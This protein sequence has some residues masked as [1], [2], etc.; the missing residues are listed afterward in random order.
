MQYDIIMSKQSEK[1][2][3]TTATNTETVLIVNPS[4][5]SGTTGKNWNDFYLKV[6]EFFGQ[7]PEV[8]FTTKAGDGTSLT[9][10]Y[11]QKGFKNI[12]AIGGDGT[13]NE[14][15][16]GFFIFNGVEENNYNKRK[17]VKAVVAGGVHSKG[18]SSHNDR[19]IDTT[20]SI[21]RRPPVKQINP[22]A[23]FGI[24][25]SGTRNVLVKSLGLPAG[26]E[27]C[28]KY[29][30]ASKMQKK[31]DVISVTV[32][33]FPD[34]DD[35]DSKN[36]HSKLA[37]TR[38]FLNAAEIGVAA[39]IIDRSK[40]IRDK[41]KSRMVSTVS[42][43]VATLPT[44]QS[45]LCEISVDDG[46]ENILTKMTMV[47]IANGR[48][49]GGGF[50][51][52]PKASMSDGL[53]DIVILKNSG[54]FKM[55]E[56][57]ISMKNGNYT[58]DDQDIIYIQAKKVSIKPKQEEEHKGKKRGDITVTIDGEPIGILPATFQ[59]HQDALTIKM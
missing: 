10:E 39:E 11:L 27:E 36:T 24:I 4:S 14:V 51:A 59:V 8:A 1:S 26:S 56:E 25:S 55:L 30:A 7:N 34:N 58:S 48:Y 46:R 19:G 18:D 47:V 32:T 54:S 13:I 15:A 44:Y 9:R 20:N 3:A 22:D 37:P 43:V 40:K 31:I 16:N 38:I 49:L 53:L 45:N 5:S 12:V 28:C 2:V 35:S 42:S 57:F 50:Q 17:V 41:V 21:T 29:Y 52:A 23:V 6:K 33:N